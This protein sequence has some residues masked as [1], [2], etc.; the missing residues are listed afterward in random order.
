MSPWLSKRVLRTQADERLAALSAEGHEEAF[1]A[2][3]S[4]YREPLLAFA[5]G[6]G[7][8]ARAEDVVQQALMQAWL[9][10]QGG[11]EVEHVRGWLYQATRRAAW[12]AAAA[13]K[14]DELPAT[15][16]AAADTEGEVERRLEARR[17]LAELQLLPERQRDALV[18]VALEGRA[19]PEVAGELGVTEN[20]FRQL[21]FRARTALRGAAGALLPLPLVTW[22]AARSSSSPPMNERLAGLLGAGGATGSA[23]AGAAGSAAALTKLAAVVAVAGAIA[24][25]VAVRHALEATPRP[26]PEAGAS[27]QDSTARRPKP[28]QLLSA[29]PHQS[30]AHR[31][32]AASQ[33]QPQV[34]SLGREA[35]AVAVPAPAPAPA[36]VPAPSENAGGSTPPPQH[37]VPVRVESTGGERHAGDSAPAPE[38]SAPPQTSSEG[39]GEQTDSTSS[40][41]SDSTPEGSG[42]TSPEGSGSTSPQSPGS[43]SETVSEGEDA[44]SP[45]EPGE[46]G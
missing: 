12:R 46:D 22:A 21:V 14:T 6:L 24:G 5:R 1:A 38:P 8:G 32:G 28:V 23:A 20:A 13:P 39:D 30:S 27:T 19:G 41:S 3:V 18:G 34:R 36:P 26:G 33:A 35:T 37:S 11:T 2:L 10:L 31:S 7:S 17:L 4:R 25:G 15:L 9:A 45:P 42:S 43:S 40:E 44:P 29:R 16:G